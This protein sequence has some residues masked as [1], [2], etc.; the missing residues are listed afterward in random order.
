VGTV[1]PS[2]SFGCLASRGVSDGGIGQQGKGRSA[3]M[4]ATR[5]HQVTYACEKLLEQVT[6]IPGISN[7]ILCMARV[8]TRKRPDF[9]T[10][11]QAA[12][13]SGRNSTDCR[14]RRDEA[15]TQAN[16]HLNSRRAATEQVQRG[17]PHRCHCLTKSIR[18]Y[19]FRV[20]P[21]FALPV[22]SRART[23]SLAWF[24]GSRVILD[25]QEKP[26]SPR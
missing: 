1:H 14:W 20:R 11:Y 4:I 6:S 7:L 16:E 21:D 12:G 10:I 9:K 2:A 17:P 25:V 18:T 3:P 15:G 26:F 23:T 13:F 19:D 5:S 22:T 24:T 8:R